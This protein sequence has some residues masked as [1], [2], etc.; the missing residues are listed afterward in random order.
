MKKLIFLLKK[1]PWRI[2]LGVVGL[3]LL[4]FFRYDYSF[5]KFDPRGPLVEIRRNIYTGSIHYRGFGSDKWISLDAEIQ[6][7]RA[8]DLQVK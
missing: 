4:Y 2:F 6:S 8:K 7:E 5:V 3:F 1:Y